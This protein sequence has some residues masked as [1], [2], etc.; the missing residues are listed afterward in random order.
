MLVIYSY[1]MAKITQVLHASKTHSHISTQDLE[2][3][4]NITQSHASQGPLRHHFGE[5]MHMVFF[6]GQC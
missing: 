6:P 4:Q 1:S 2:A 3:L 5:K